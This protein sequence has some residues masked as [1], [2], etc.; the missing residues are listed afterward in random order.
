MNTIFSDISSVIDCATSCRSDTVRT[1]RTSEEHS[2][3]VR[4]SLSGI[5]TY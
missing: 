4:E 3:R 5:K 2:H 1:T